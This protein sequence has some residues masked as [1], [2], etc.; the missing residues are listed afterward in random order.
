M[1]Q[2]HSLPVTLRQPG[3]SSVSCLPECGQLGSAGDQTEAEE[4]DRP[5]PAALLTKT[6]SYVS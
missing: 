2:Q 3:L 4:G 6:P 5:T 1:S